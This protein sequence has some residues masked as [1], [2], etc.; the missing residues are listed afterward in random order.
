MNVFKQFILSMRFTGL[1]NVFRSLRYSLFRDLVERQHPVP[2]P[3]GEAHPPGDLKEMLEITSGAK[4]HFEFEESPSDLEILFLKPDLVRVSWSPGLPPL[5]YAL[6]QQDWSEVPV[7]IQEADGAWTLKTDCLEVHVK[8]DGGLEYCLLDGA[9]LRSEPPPQRQGEISEEDD[10]DTPIYW[11]QFASLAPEERVY[12]LGEQSA[13]LN[14]RGGVYH[15]WNSD[16]G[17]AYGRG[18]QPLYAPMPVYLGMHRQ[19]SYLVFYENPFPAT[20][21]LPANP[22][23]TSSARKDV[24]AKKEHVRASFK[25]GMLRY[26]FSPGPPARALKNFS[27][28]TGRSPLPPLWA[29]G[30]H[31]CRWGY[32]DEKHVRQVVQGFKNHNLPLSAI[33]LDID[34]MQ[35]YRVF[36]V[37]E[38]RFPD[39]SALA[40]DLDQEENHA[41][42]LHP[43]GIRMVAILD[44]GI[45]QD[46]NFPLFM[47]A[48]REK[49]LCNLPDG[50]PF[51]GPVWPGW[52]GFPDFTDPE[53]RQWWGSKYPF[54]L[55]KGV[56]GFW[57]DMN[58][59]S[60]FAARGELTFPQAT[61][62]SLEKRSGDH[63]QAHNLYGLLMNRSGYEALRKHQ[64]ENRP[65][66]LS[67]SGWPGMQRYAWSWTADTQTSWESLRMTIPTV[68]GMGLSG[69]PYSGPDVGG[70][71]GVPSAELYLRWLQAAAFMP[72]FRTHSALGMPERE[73]WVYGE[74]Y[75]SHAR[76]VLELRYRLLPYLYTLAWETSQSG[77]PIVRPLFWAD[78]QDEELWDV[79]D[80][81]FLGDA[82]LVAP[83]VQEGTARRQVRLPAGAWFD[84]WNE[85]LYN[86][87]GEIEL[88]GDLSRIP[89]LVRSGS[90][91]P[92]EKEKRLE[93]HL[94][95]PAEQPPSDRASGGM[96]Y[97]DAGDGY[98][99]RRLDHFS[100]ENDSQGL[101]LSW[102][103]QGDYEF[104]YQGVTLVVHGFEAEQAQVDGAQV[105]ISKNRV[106]LESFHQILIAIPKKG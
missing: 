97:S 33:H 98:G 11:T 8:P 39:L 47:E 9:K 35:E 65:W 57:H 71:N 38:T 62:H 64:P 80:T 82:L 78:P 76:Q 73:P 1:V 45:K 52:C 18:D 86:G 77:I 20:I 51:I 7:S 104:P 84:F 61:R 87:P 70:F 99:D 41:G 5:P 50:K 88:P 31:Q 19:G 21:A 105:K 91:L 48:V 59:P 27:A 46:L 60:V 68:L 66:L 53:A 15:L 12:G 81:F 74:P 85:R 17:G 13:G 40:R 100:I 42:G 22:Q 49:V 34:Y 6:A 55:E 58:E 56:R 69:V 24:A 25:G 32:K 30:Y 89:L 54:L 10:S 95:W 28:L 3:S 93:L 26:Y 94:Y 14:L 4:F 92:M 63:R 101:N 75:T 103:S 23:G 36:T 90:I 72:F 67:R 43:P 16:P 44:P 106:E 37:D 79:E 102:E 83:V 2:R 29:L 96:L